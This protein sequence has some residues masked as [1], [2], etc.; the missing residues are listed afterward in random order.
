[1]NDNGPG[2]ITRPSPVPLVPLKQLMLPV[3]AMV[4]KVG[5][6]RDLARLIQDGL[7]ERVAGVA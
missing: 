5:R 3:D 4:L 2:P 1:M 6:L 7:E